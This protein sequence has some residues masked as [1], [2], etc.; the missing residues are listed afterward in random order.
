MEVQI[1]PIGIFC[2]GEGKIKRMNDE[3][4]ET[5][6]EKKFKKVK[7]QFDEGT[8]S[9][10]NLRTIPQDK[11]TEYLQREIAKKYNTKEIEFGCPTCAYTVLY[12]D[13][14]YITDEDLLADEKVAKYHRH[15]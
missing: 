7:K 13:K 4:M 12:T 3:K 2:V 1:L 14:G 9:K 8:L 6:K 5:R 10:E 15:K 11:Q